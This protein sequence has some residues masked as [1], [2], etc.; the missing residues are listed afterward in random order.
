MSLAEH[1]RTLGRGPGR[2]RSLTREEATDAMRQM[3]SGEAA[4]EAVGAILMLLRMKGETAPEIA[5]FAEAAQAGIAPVGGVDLDWPSYAA[6]RTRGAPL[7]LHA[8]RRI[9]DDGHRVLLHGWNG[10]DRK[11]RDGLPDAGIGMAATATEAEALLARDGIAYMTLETAHP[12][13]F[14]LLNLRDTFG[15]RSC[16]NTVCRMLNPGR[17]RASVQGV[18]HPSYRLLQADAAALLGWDQLSVIKGG[19]GE[20]ERNPAKVIAGF[21]LR[22]GAPWEGSYPALSDETRRLSESG[23][24]DFDRLV[25]EATA[26]LARDTLRGVVRSA[27]E[28]AVEAL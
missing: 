26:E 12:A 5:G 10:A 21:G 3:L 18:F 23:D 22:N 1:V 15:L 20:F 28:D 4:P 25:V 27:P 9:A 11:V 24:A 6:G 17:A 8:A 2:S 13:L 14:A 19:G 16:V 7:F